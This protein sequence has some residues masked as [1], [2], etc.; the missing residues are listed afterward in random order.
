MVSS[1]SGKILQENTLW[2]KE[3]NSMEKSLSDDIRPT[4][5]AQRHVLDALGTCRAQESALNLIRRTALEVSK[6]RS[7]TSEFWVLMLFRVPA[8]LQAGE[9]R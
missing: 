7:K 5:T 2:R 1:L 8:M 9:K 6:L 3:K 4:T